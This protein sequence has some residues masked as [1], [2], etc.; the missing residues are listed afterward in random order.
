MFSEAVCDVSQNVFPLCVKFLASKHEAV[1]SFAGLAV[2]QLLDVRDVDAQQPVKYTL[3]F[4]RQHLKGVLEP[5][6]TAIATALSKH[7]EENAYVI[8]AL[9]RVIS[10]AETD[11]VGLVAKL[12]QLI[13][14]RIA[15]SY[16]QPKNPLFGH[17][18]WD[19]LAACVKVTVQAHGDNR[20]SVLDEYEKQLF[21]L[22]EKILTE[23]DAD[24]YAPFVFQVMAMLIELRAGA[25]ATIAQRRGT[26]KPIYKNVFKRLTE[27]VMWESPGNIPALT[28][29]LQA[30]VEHDP[31]LVLSGDLLGRVLGVFQRLISSKANDFLGFYLLQSLTMALPLQALEPHIPQIL[32]LIFMRLQGSKTMQL[33]KSF[34]IFL[35]YFTGRHSATVTIQAV[36]SVQPEYDVCDHLFA[37]HSASIFVMVLQSIWEPTVTLVRGAAERKACAVAGIQLL[38]SPQLR[39]PPYV[40]LWFACTL[41]RS[42]SPHL[43]IFRPSIMKSVVMLLEGAT[44][45]ASAAAVTGT[46]LAV[47]EHAVTRSYCIYNVLDKWLLLTSG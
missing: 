39:Q 6:L 46:V 25:N 22:F 27:P 44:S 33:M 45:E 40:N 31:E 36:N 12:V 29:L 32:R 37:S 19:A 17:Y 21:P 10:V 18:L 24:A 3:R 34:C 35:A 9:S 47:D 28:R 41:P 2:D 11:T 4:G 26:L 30:Y 43:T 1:R 23:A 13:G 5:T 42:G 16:K 20:A 14:S 15:A 38:T 7:A 8:R